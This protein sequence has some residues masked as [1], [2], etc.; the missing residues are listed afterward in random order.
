M[1]ESEI[2]PELRSYVFYVGKYN[3]GVK[4]VK[5]FL[6]TFLCSGVSS[7]DN[8]N[9]NDVGL[10]SSR[11]KKLGQIFICPFSVEL[12]HWTSVCTDGLCIF[13]Y[14]PIC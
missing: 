5:G 6:L 4:Y 13:N 3:K 10:S 11:T 7:E 14:S 2:Y 12:S 1:S 9:L 8:T